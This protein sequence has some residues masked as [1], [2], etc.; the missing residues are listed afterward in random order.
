[1]LQFTISCGVGGDCSLFDD[2]YGLCLE[3]SLGLIVVV[4][5]VTYL[6]LCIGGLNNI[7]EWQMVFFVV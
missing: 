5:L 3:C 2:M 6:W 7:C 1:M 4:F